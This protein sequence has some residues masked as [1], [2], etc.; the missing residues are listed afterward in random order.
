MVVI[1]VF[2]IINIV[3]DW[4]I[5]A[6]PVPVV[7]GLHMEKRTKWS[8]CALFMLGGFVCV[9][10]IVRLVYAKKAE[11]PD[12]SC[13]SFNPPRLAFPRLSGCADEMCRGLSSNSF[14]QHCRSLHWHSC[15]VHADVAATAEVPSSWHHIVLYIEQVLLQGIRPPVCQRQ[16][17]KASAITLSLS[18]ARVEC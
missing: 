16:D 18:D 2:G 10:S 7:M 5:L 12:T 17:P 1:I 8:I 3:T 4:W 6:L 9:I 14:G 13:K 15:R 11:T